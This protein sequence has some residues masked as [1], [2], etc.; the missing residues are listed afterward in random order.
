MI[1]R[2]DGNGFDSIR[3]YTFP[4]RHYTKVRIDAILIETKL[5][6]GGN[7]LLWIGREGPCNKLVMI[8]KP[9]RKAMNA[10]DETT[11]SATNHAQTN[12]LMR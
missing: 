5:P 6:A 9:R 7:R 12:A 2:D 4:L 10:T 3:P 8:V 11:Q 1:R